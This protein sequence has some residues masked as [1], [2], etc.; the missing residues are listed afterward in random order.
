MPL[1]DRHALSIG[2]T[3]VAEQGFFGIYADRK[4][5]H[6]IAAE[7]ATLISATQGGTVSADDFKGSTFTVT[8]LGMFGIDAFTPI[9]NLPECAILGLGRI[10][11]RPVVI[12]E[13]TG[14]IA[15]RKMMAL[16]LTFDHRVVDGATAARFLQNFARKIERP[17][18]W[19]TR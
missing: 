18:T 15:A 13:E 8:N 11:S 12:D 9:I 4:S 3:T 5:V 10:Q 6:Q 1:A 19:L 17:F 16:S 7:T 2:F 14:V